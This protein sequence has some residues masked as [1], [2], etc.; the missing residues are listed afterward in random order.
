MARPTL[1]SSC[2][3]ILVSIWTPLTHEVAAR[4]FTLPNFLFLRPCRW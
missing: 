4:W 3:G 2:V 1:R